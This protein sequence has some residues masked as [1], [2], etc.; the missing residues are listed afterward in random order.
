MNR[1][2]GSIDLT[3]VPGF[4]ADGPPAKDWQDCADTIAGLGVAAFMIGFFGSLIGA[5]FYFL[6]AGL[7]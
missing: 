7:L 2:D 3:A 1:S 5:G 6:I 4:K